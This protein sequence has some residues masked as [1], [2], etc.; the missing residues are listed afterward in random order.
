LH[1]IGDLFELN[2]PYIGRSSCISLLA[3]VNKSSRFLCLD[4]AIIFKL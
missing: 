3:E 4:L 1:L 2:L